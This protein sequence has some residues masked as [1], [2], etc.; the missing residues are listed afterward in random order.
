MGSG[1]LRIAFA[2]PEYVTEK[3][4]DGGLANHTHRVA[5]AL[6]GMGHDIHVLTLSDIDDAEFVHDGVTVHRIKSRRWWSRLEFS[7]NV[8]RALKR[9]DSQQALDL[10]Q[11][12]NYSSCGVVSMC[13]LRVPYVLRA[14]SYQP[15][16]ND[17]L[18]VRRTLKVRMA[19]RP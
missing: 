19:C 4:F 7:I 11:F 13:C 6:A 17:A 3:Y 18:G 9:I 12:P 1:F 5:K 16:L 2:T 8:H 10:V 15:A 14:S